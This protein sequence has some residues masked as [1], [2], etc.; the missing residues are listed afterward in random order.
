[1][2]GFSGAEF[3]RMLQ[4]TRR[5]LESMGSGAPAESTPSTDGPSRK[6]VGEAA[7][8]RVKVS[9]VAGGRLEGLELDA[10]AM[11][12]GS[13]ELAEQILVAVNNALDDLQARSADQAAGVADP[14]ALA[15]RVQG[16]QDQGVRQMEEVN[17]SIADMIA[18]FSTSG[19]H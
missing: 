17:R 10:R 2:S 19:P 13:Q 6:G 14:A 3:D 4:E 8:G 1:L 5:V 16:I 15:A 18:R 12:L 7:D 9:A 11:R